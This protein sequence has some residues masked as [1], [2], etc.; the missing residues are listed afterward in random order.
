MLTSRSFPTLVV[1][2]LT[3][4]ALGASCGGP[5][6]TGTGARASDFALQD[7]D[8]RTVHLSDYLGKS[9][10]LVNFWATWCTPCMGEMPHLQR[11]HEQYGGQGLVILGISMDGP[12][13]VANVGPTV[14][15]MGITYPVLLDQETRVVGTYNPHKDAPYNVLIGRDGVIVKSKVGYAAGDEKGLEEDLKALLAAPQGS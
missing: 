15:R 14:R 11:L 10:V 13:T 8:G 5:Q 6:N 2:V 4:G 7:V 12:E 3:M 1:T 9:V